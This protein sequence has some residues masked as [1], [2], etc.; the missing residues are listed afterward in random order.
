MER[1][2]HLYD[3]HVKTIMRLLRVPA[4]DFEDV[5]Q[6]IRLEILR[7]YPGFQ[8]NGR[9]GAFR[10]W[11][12][13]II[14]RQVSAYWKER[15]SRENFV[16]KLALKRLEELKNDKS[17]VSRFRDHEEDCLL[18]KLALQKMESEGEA[19]PREILAFRKV[20]AGE[21]VADVARDLGV[22]AKEVSRWKYKVLNLLRK[23]FGEWP[24]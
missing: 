17:L 10:N 8:H 6:G 20:F 19:G 14:E 2:F 22:K 3:G 16:D 12:R 15:I 18:V 11:L 21:K 13:T 4:N 9:T 1:L 7:S 24:E 23:H 5:F